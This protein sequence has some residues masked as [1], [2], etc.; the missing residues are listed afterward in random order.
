MIDLTENE[1]I[2]NN[3][4]Q[5]LNFIRTDDEYVFTKMSDYCKDSVDRLIE[6]CNK[7]E[8]FSLTHTRQGKYEPFLNRLKNEIKKVILGI[9]RTYLTFHDENRQYMDI[10]MLEWVQMKIDAPDFLSISYWS[11]QDN[12][13]L[14][15]IERYI[16][17]F[18]DQL[19]SNSTE[20]L[21]KIIFQDLRIL[22]YL[23]LDTYDVI[24]K[25]NFLSR[26]NS[27]GKIQLSANATQNK[28]ESLN[29]KLK[30]FELCK[31]CYRTSAGNEVCDLHKTSHYD[32]NKNY[33]MAR[34]VFSSL[35]SEEKEAHVKLK[36]V[37][38]EYKW[39]RKRVGFKEFQ[40]I[41]AN[42]PF[43]KVI[44]ITFQANADVIFMI[45]SL[46][47]RNWDKIGKP[48]L[49]K[50]MNS[51]VHLKE[52]LSPII[53]NSVSLEDVTKKLYSEDGLHNTYETSLH[54]YWLLQALNIENLVLQ[55]ANTKKLDRNERDKRY[56]T[57]HT[58]QKMTY[59]EIVKSEISEGYMELKPNQTIKSK[60]SNVRQRIN[61]YKDSI[62]M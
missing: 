30:E 29:H 24:N 43:D 47:Q 62:E 39:Q 22:K 52:I 46:L 53:A 14:Y 3:L 27:S 7:P 44:S 32:G 60:A 15:S 33:T 57:K 28:L 45:D 20:K 37:L 50:F 13:E 2:R 12:E 18:T 40:L 31:Y 59:P 10:T 61:I 38:N 8:N 54:P 56:Y 16:D 49:L 36:E 1:E 9:E 5:K 25:F 48:I 41:G 58:E 17:I 19:K 35:E 34:K 23:I 4:I 55:V 11:K 6:Y 21:I 42:T 51:L 26:I